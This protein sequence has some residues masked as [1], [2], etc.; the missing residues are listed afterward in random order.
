MRTG[1]PAPDATAKGSAVAAVLVGEVTG[2]TVRALV[3][4]GVSSGPLR[5]HQRD[6]WRRQHD[7][8]A[9]PG[10]LATGIRAPLSPA[11]AKELLAAGRAGGGRVVT[12]VVTRRHFRTHRSAQSPRRR[13]EQ[14]RWRAGRAAGSPLRGGT[15]VLPRACLQLPS[16]AA[17]RRVANASRSLRGGGRSRSWTRP[18]SSPS[19][20]SRG[21][22]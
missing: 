15:A 13:R 21:R 5:E 16:E 8:A 3:D 6:L 17:C 22:R 11:G 14:S 2:L 7:I 4:S 18:G 10:R 1:P 20:S 9:P 19:R 12:V